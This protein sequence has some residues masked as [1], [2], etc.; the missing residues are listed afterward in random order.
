MLDTI[1]PTL[2]QRLRDDTRD[3]HDALDA[4][5]AMADLASVEG[6]ARFLGSQWLAFESLVAGGVTGH[7]VRAAE[8]VANRE[9]LAADMAALGR[10]LPVRLDEA[11]P[12]DPVAVDYVILGSGVGKVYLRR[13]WAA[14]EDACVRRASRWFDLPRAA[15]DW[16]G[17]LTDLSARD[18]AT[19]DAVVADARTLFALFLRAFERGMRP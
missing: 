2:R 18:G 10:D 12:A 14:S 4:M 5:V 13:A 15:G 6:L 7:R 11:A 19:G 17:H 16:H 3:A 1:N 9:A 8:M